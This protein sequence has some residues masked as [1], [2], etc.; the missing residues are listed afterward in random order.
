MSVR[1][2]RWSCLSLVL[3]AAVAPAARTA[4]EPL[5]HHEIAFTR[6]PDAKGKDRPPGKAFLWLPPQGERVRGLIVA[7]MTLLE[8]RFTADPQIRQA[9]ADEQLAI[10]FFNPG[11]D[12]L[13]DYVKNRSGEKLE[14]LLAE[15]AK[16][17]RHPE[18]V[19]APMLTVGHSTAGIF[20]RNIAYWKP[21]RI[22]G[23]IHIKSGNLHQHIYGDNKS[24]AGVPWLSISGEFEEHGPEGGLRPEYGRETQWIMHG[25]DL[26]ARRAADPAHLMSML[27]HPGGN[28]TSW[29]DNLSRYCVLFIR[30]A[31]AARVPREAGDGKSAVQCLAVKPESG[32]LTDGDIKSPRHKMAPYREYQGD[33]T[34]AFWHFDSEIA[35][36]T[37]VFHHDKFSL[38]RQGVQGHR[39][40]AYVNGGHERQKL[41]LHLPEKFAG[42][43]PVLV[44]IHGGAWNHGDKAGGPAAPFVAKGYAVACLHYRFSQHALFPAQL[45]DCKAAIRW[46]RGNADKYGL[47]PDHFAV[48]G[49]SAGGHLAALVGATGD[50]KDFDTVG[51]HRDQSSRVQAV[52]DWFGPTDFAQMGEKSTDPKSAE[53]Q[54]LGVAPRT[55]PAKAARANPVTYLRQGAPPFLI[56]HGEED[57]GVPIQQSELLAEALKKAGAEVTLVRIAGAGHGGDAFRTPERMQRI[58]EFL[59]R[60]LRAGQSSPAK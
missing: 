24:L 49:A 48:W 50:G 34:R 18:I 57:K 28:H 38:P 31:V 1:N 30:K 46:L 32:W 25:R 14:S 22:I 20:A 10:V 43:L 4:D 6:G 36:A 19:H 9:A 59:A 7:Q 5:W 2:L 17:S 54:L 37:T 3:L 29:D 27:V 53:S 51:D 13:F 21:E 23:V 26:L 33:Q 12:A 55:D 35:R 44:W 45:E 52:I 8:K 41:D 58:E 39:N 42:R 15:L 60:H 40:L 56:L 11:F 16:Q 47:D